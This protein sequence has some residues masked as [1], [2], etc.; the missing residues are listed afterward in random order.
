MPL[1]RFLQR[2][3]LEA[4]GMKDFHVSNANLQ[5][6]IVGFDGLMGLDGDDVRFLK[7]NDIDSCVLRCYCTGGESGRWAWG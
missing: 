7:P 5:R 4:L 2:S 6:L 3:A 1:Y